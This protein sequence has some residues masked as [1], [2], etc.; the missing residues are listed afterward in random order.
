MRILKY[1]DRLVEEV[2][3]VSNEKV[4]FLKYIREEDK[5]PH[6]SKPIEREISIVENC[7]NWK[8]D[9]KGVES[10]PPP[11]ISRVTK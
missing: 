8:E 5:C 2:G 9:I 4:V 10:L 7:P 1:Q 6:C 11:T 3:Y